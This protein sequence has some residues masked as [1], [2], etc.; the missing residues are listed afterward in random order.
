VLEQGADSVF[1]KPAQKKIDEIDQMLTEDA[2]R[3]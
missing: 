3:I 1:G 2:S